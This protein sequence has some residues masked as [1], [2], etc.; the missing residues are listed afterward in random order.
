LRA[1]R[2]GSKLIEL[3]H[4][5]RHGMIT[6]PGLPGPTIGDHLSWEDSHSRYAPGTEF[7]IGAMTLVANTGTYIDAPA[8]RY[9]SGSDLAGLGLAS[10][11]NLPSVVVRVPPDTVRIDRKLLGAYH[12]DG[13]A[14]L[15]HTGWDQHWGTATYGGGGHPYVTLDG[16]A[17]LAE[18]GATLVG[19]DSV[20]IDDFEDGTRPAHSTLLSH[21]IPIV[22]HLRGLEQLPSDG[23]RFFAAP[24]LIEGMATFPVR[25]FALVD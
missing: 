6:H 12:V 25:A 8:H 19:I 9:R 15:I 14:V 1:V 23:F 24:P 10:L 20:N 2:D 3:S 5:I 18:A 21:A 4:P 11:V 16:A 13:M 7:Q 22:E 17:Q